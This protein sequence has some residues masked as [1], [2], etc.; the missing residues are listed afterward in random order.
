MLSRK[1]SHGSHQSPSTERDPDSISSHASTAAHEAD[2]H[3]ISSINPFVQASI[4]L[5]SEYGSPQ[6]VC[7]ANDRHK[8]LENARFASVRL[9]SPWF[10]SVDPKN[11]QAKSFRTWRSRRDITLKTICLVA[12]IVFLV[13][14]SATII[15]RLKWGTGQDINT[16]STGDCSKMS[17]I[18]TGVH[19]IINVLSTALL[20]ASNLCMQLLVAPTRSE[21]D[22]A[23][24]K[25]IWLDIG[26]SSVRNMKYISG[27]RV[28]VCLFLAISSLPLHFLY[29]HPLAETQVQRVKINADHTYV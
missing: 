8:V 6:N 10:P 13:N 25:F 28:K 3:G 23:H 17:N 18:N 19:V 12:G 2:R 24:A 29:V 1:P 22:K 5:K 16:L 21:V 4:H 26:V 9:L 27:H 14:L 7:A 15:M 11:E 20:G